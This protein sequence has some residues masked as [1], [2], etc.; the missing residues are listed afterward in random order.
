MG[1]LPCSLPKW[2]PPPSAEPFLPSAAPCQNLP[3]Y[4]NTPNLHHKISTGESL[5][6][7][8]QFEF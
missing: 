4:A 5:A 3:T 6:R 2:P 1:H 7:P 8:L